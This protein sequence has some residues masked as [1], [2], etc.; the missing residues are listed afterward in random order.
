MV[1]LQL[2][3]KYFICKFRGKGYYL[4]II[5]VNLLWKDVGLI[6][7]SDQGFIKEMFKD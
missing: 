6:C 3:F 2:K 4:N 5:V 7:G 1:L